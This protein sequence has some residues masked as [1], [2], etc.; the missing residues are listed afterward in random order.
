MK[1]KAAREKPATTAVQPS[2]ST[3][4]S[5]AAAAPEGAWFFAWLKSAM[6]YLAAV[7]AYLGAVIGFL[8]AFNKVHP[9]K[10]DK[11]DTATYALASVLA[12]P[13]LFALLFNVLPALRRRWERGLRPTREARQ[14]ASSSYF[15]TSPREDDSYGFFAQGYESFLEWARAPRAPLLHLTGLSGSGKSSLLSAYLKPNLAAPASGNKTLLI[16]VRSYHDPL[17]SLKEALLTQWKKKPVGYESLSPLEALQRAA[18]QLDAEDR[19]LVAF[20]QFEEFF[21]LRANLAAEWAKSYGTATSTA[22][23]KA[24]IAPLRDFLWAFLANPPA[25]VTLLLSYR[26]DHRRLL[27]PLELPIRQDRIN[28][29]TIDPFDFTAAAAFL[30]SCPGLMIPEGRMNLVLKEAARQEGGRVVMRPIVANLLGIVL[31]QMADHPTRCRRRSDLLRGYVQDCL[32]VELKE[33][34][35]RFLRA[36]LTDSASARP[37]AVADIARES[38]LHPA[39]LDAHLDH[40]G[41][42]GLLRCLNPEEHDPSRRVWQIAHDFLA[43]LIER[44]LDGMHRTLWRTVRPWLAPAAVSVAIVLFLMMPWI[45]KQR[46]R[47][48]L[49]HAG[50]NWDEPRSELIVATD[51]GRSLTNLEPLSASLHRIKSRRINLGACTALQNVNSLA[52]LTSL[53][54]LDLS[55]CRKLENVDGLKGLISLTTL[56]LS[57]CEALTNIGGLKSLKFLER[58]NLDYCTELANADFEGLVSLRYLNLGRCPKLQSVSDLHDLHSLQWLNLFDCRKL[59]SISLDGLTALQFLFV[60][61]CDSLTNISDGKDLSCLN[62]L[63]LAECR[64][65][66][67]IDG[68]TNLIG[69]TNLL[70]NGCVSIENV[71]SLVGATALRELDLGYCSRLKNVNGVRGLPAL[72]VLV[73]NSC[74]ELQNVDGISGLASLKQL[75]LNDCEAISNV[76]RLQGLSSLEELFL[77]GCYALTNLN[78]LKNLPTLQ[79]LNIAACPKLQNLDN[80]QGLTSLRELWLHNCLALTNVDG[81]RTLSSLRELDLFGCSNLQK[82]SWMALTSA[83]PKCIII[84]PNP[85][86]KGLPHKVTE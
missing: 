18:R 43:T 75:F 84:P 83:L 61:S 20:D 29:M 30:R 35:A 10:H 60:R 53:Q 17:A 13:L 86:W 70:L 57:G 7:T 5:E 64:K 73:L 77:G 8:A 71:D 42:A 58:V 34:R 81:I 37:R 49:A 82:E 19:L 1:K 16:I 11:A 24:E 78:G 14:H 51:A 40:F 33:E 52:G 26:D 27:A 47:E 2:S 66:T 23:A 46:D 41:H 9:D 74:R 12:L 32:G 55:D 79:V 72:Q 50:F 44:V 6:L 31:R 45:Q 85:A 4:Q 76:D 15:Q 39:D 62:G 48:L 65:L 63:D 3:L 80:L 67:S 36:M 69:L 68:F 21:L 38:E 54:H 28:S 22:V 56:N 59:P 25:R